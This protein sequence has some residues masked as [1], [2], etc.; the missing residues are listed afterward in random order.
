MVPPTGDGGSPALIDRPILKFLQ[1]RLQATQ[2]VEQAAIT[3]ASGHLELQVSFTS[4]YYPATVSEATL[5]VRWYTNN[6]FK[7]QYREKES[8]S[9][10]ECRWDRH[11]NPHNTRN[12]FHPPPAAPTPGNDAS[13]PTDHRDVLSLVLNEIEERISALWND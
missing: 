3:D 7:I 13:W 12:H 4:S 5:T 8:E 9:A 6:D 2:Q 10:W 11:L 1:T